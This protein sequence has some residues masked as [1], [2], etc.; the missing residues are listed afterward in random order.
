MLQRLSTVPPPTQLAHAEL[1]GLGQYHFHDEVSSD[2]DKSSAADARIRVS[3]SIQASS[4]CTEVATASGLSDGDLFYLNF[5][6]MKPE[7]ILG[8]K[9]A[10]AAWLDNG[11]LKV[12]RVL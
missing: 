8:P 1:K 9:D 12:R 7:A 10:L 4:K 6:K 5:D 3:R 2:V 11:C